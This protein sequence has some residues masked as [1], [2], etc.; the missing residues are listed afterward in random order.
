MESIVSW[1]D[2][3][4]DANKVVSWKVKFTVRDY[5]TFKDLGTLLLISHQFVS[6]L[7]EN[8]KEVD[9]LYFGYNHPKTEEE[10]IETYIRHSKKLDSLIKQE[11]P[12]LDE[13]VKVILNGEQVVSVFN[14]DFEMEYP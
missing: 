12:T 6:L 2:K 4:F 1:G 14:V 3:T 5:V 7:D 10:Y 8:G 9:E 11:K 13:D